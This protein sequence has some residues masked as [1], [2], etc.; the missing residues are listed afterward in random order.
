MPSEKLDQF[1]ACAMP[2]KCTFRAVAARYVKKLRRP[3]GWHAGVPCVPYLQLWLMPGCTSSL[4]ASYQPSSTGAQ[5]AFWE[6]SSFGCSHSQWCILTRSTAACIT[7]CWA[8]HLLP[9]QKTTPARACMLT[10]S[11]GIDPA[12]AA[13]MGWVA[14]LPFGHAWAA[15]FPANSSSVHKAGIKSMAYR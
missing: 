1:W 15:I 7:G 3:R 9:S 5:V 2:S 13:A 10:F 4:S 8:L 6:G 14:G 12:P 11:T